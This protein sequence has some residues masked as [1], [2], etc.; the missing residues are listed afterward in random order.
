M[1]TYLALGIYL[2][3]AVALGSVFVLASQIARRGP[4]PYPEVAGRAYRLR[5]FWFFALG[6][7]LAA[8]LLSTIPYVPYATYRLASGP[9]AMH[10]N[11]T[12][13][14]YTWTMA[15]AVTT[16]GKVDFTVASADVNHGFGIYDPSGHLIGQVQAMPGYLNHLVMQFSAPG[17]YTIRCLEY[18]GPGHSSMF[19]TMHIATCQTGCCC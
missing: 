10:V 16:G 8:I 14:Q 2:V 11:V 3:G 6:G 7:T 1:I 18:C 12:A 13:S 15:G 4:T 17:D 9:A 19:M 5:L